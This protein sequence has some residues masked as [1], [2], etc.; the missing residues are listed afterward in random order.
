MKINYSFLILG[1][2]ISSAI[3]AQNGFR[4]GHTEAMNAVFAEHPEIKAKLEKSEAELEKL[5]KEAFKTGY[6]YGYNTGN[7][8]VQKSSGVDATV[9]TVPIVFHILHQDGVEKIDETQVIDAVKI[10]NRDFAKLNADTTDVI[11]AFKNLIGKADIQFKLATIDPNGKCTNGIIYH[12]D[13]NTDWVQKDISYYKYTGTGAGQ[14]NPTKY[15]NIYVVK[16][17]TAV[18]TGNPKTGVAGYTYTPGTW[19]SGSGYDAVVLL[20]DYIGSIGT[21]TSGGRDRALTHEVGHWFNLQHLWGSTNQPGVDCTGSDGVSD[22]PVTQGYESCPLASSPSKY[23][24]CTPGVSENYQNYMDYSYCSVMFTKGQV[25][26]MRSAIV[27]NS[28]GRNNLWSSA[29][30]SAT[31][32]TSPQ[33]CV[34]VA[35]FSSDKTNDC[36]GKTVQY[37]DNSTNAHPTGWSWSFPGGTPS[38]STDSMPIVTYNS[39]GLYAVTY[40]ATTTKGSNTITKNNYLNVVNS[41]AAYQTQF[42]EGFETASFPNADWKVVNKTGGVTWTIVSTAASEGTKS[43]KIDNTQNTARSMDELIGPTINTENINTTNNGIYFTFKVAHQQSASTQKDKLQVLTSTN[44]GESWTARYSKTGSFLATTTTVGTAPFTPNSTQWRQETVNCAALLASNNVMIKFAFTCDTLGA[45]N[46]IYVDDINILGTIGIDDNHIENLLDLQAYPNPSSGK[47]N[48]SFDLTEKHQ[49]SLSVCNMLGE[50]VKNIA[51]TT[52]GAG[53]HKFVLGNDAQLNSGIYFMNLS[54]D[55]KLF[56][57]K[58]II[59]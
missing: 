48:I 11:P 44:C 54:I 24:I 32:V 5:D 30:L 17:I 36:S 19:S 13:P 46:N 4:C 6:K 8:A 25:T 59:E 41:T 22:T 56:T 29:N 45:G 9:Y 16:S 55:G 47:V 14:W 15:L 2:T 43:I 34:P 31:G 58:I 49:V 12:N 51:N 27:A 23:Q 53:T 28:V 3:T 42:K 39:P 37:K 50:S 10:L 52:L 35:D 1:F 18:G 7:T 40:T 20:H 26:R 21:G 33:I 57:R 38:T